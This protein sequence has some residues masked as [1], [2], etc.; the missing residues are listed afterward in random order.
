[1]TKLYTILICI[2]FFVSRQ[3]TGYA[4]SDQSISQKSVLFYFRF[5]RS[6]LEKNYLTNNYSMDTLSAIMSD[7]DILSQM[8]SI[9]IQ[10]SASPE[11]DLSRNEQ[12]SIERAAAIKTYLMWQYPYLDRN[13]ILTYSIG[14]DWKGLKQMVERDPDVPCRS[15]LLT[16]INS[17]LDSQTKDGLLR[18]LCGGDTFLYLT[19][20]ML[21]Y[22]R[23][24]AACIVFYQKV[25]AENIEET[26]IKDD[27]TIEEPAIIPVQIDSIRT[28]VIPDNPY[29]QFK[30]PLALKSNLLFDMATLLNVEV[31]VPLGHR[32]SVAGEWIFPWWFWKR[33]QNCLEILSG[34]I[35]G[36]YWI[37]P[38]YSKQDTDLGIHNPLTGWFAG[39][40]SSAGIYD[41]EWNKKGYQGEMYLSGGVTLGYAKSLSRNLNMEFSLSAGYMQSNY[42]HYEAMQDISGEWHLIKQNSGTFRWIGP[43]KAKISLVWYPHFKR[44][45]KGGQYR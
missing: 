12:L 42:R 30:R 39:L 6:L 18:Q 10:A 26:E 14:E 22:L 41:L 17:N 4:Q 2:V 21:R 24:G 37:K 34:T 13:K 19:R 3:E 28:E 25:P 16:L 27:R 23:S 40:Y 1:M 36:R 8:D 29:Y 9:V 35:E 11:G 44:V 33:Q 7:K 15:E 31:E 5:N 45:K 38:N 20:H 32:F 43:T